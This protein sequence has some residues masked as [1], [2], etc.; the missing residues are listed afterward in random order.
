MYISPFYCGVVVGFVGCLV[1]MVAMAVLIGSD[2]KK[3]KE[4][5]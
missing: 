3:D 1:L 4:E 2:T 5:Q